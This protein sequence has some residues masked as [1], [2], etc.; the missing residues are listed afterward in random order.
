MRGGAGVG[1]KHDPDTGKGRT[2]T[3]EHGGVRECDSVDLCFKE[4]EREKEE[5]RQRDGMR[6]RTSEKE[7]RQVGVGR[8]KNKKSRQGKKMLRKLCCMMDM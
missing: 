4:K 2:E 5:Q 3:E 1:R 6:N 8:K 7:L